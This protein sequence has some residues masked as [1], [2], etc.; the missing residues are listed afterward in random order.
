MFELCRTLVPWRAPVGRDGYR[1]MAEQL[2]V[3]P[4]RFRDVVALVRAAP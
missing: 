4:Q 1:R 3:E 2:G